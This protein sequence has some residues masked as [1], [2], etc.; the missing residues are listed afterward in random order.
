MLLWPHIKFNFFTIVNPG[1][2][3]MMMTVGG[4]MVGQAQMTMVSQQQQPMMNRNVNPQQGGNLRQ[5][6]FPRPWNRCF[7]TSRRE[8]LPK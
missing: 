8:I 3:S 6:I 5:V 2:R 7:Q 1:Q 4:G